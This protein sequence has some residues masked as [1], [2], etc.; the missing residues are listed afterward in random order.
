MANIVRLPLNRRAIPDGADVSRAGAAS[1]IGPSVDPLVQ[2]LRHCLEVRDRLNAG[3][4]EAEA[5]GEQ[6]YARFS[7]MRRNIF[8]ASSSTIEGAAA[9]LFLVVDMLHAG[10][11]YDDDEIA[12]IL[13]DAAD[14]LGLPHSPE[15]RAKPE[16][17][18]VAGGR[19]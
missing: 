12:S 13:R 3:D 2:Q 17:T 16:L 11:V 7:T 6:L 19:A 1:A 5:E 9:R 10:V 18:L 4:Y 8:G 15:W 14:H